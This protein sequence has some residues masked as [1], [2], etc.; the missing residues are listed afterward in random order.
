M[1]RSEIISKRGIEYEPA[2]AYL[3]ALVSGPFVFLSGT[4]GQG[5]TEEAQG[6]SSF[7]SLGACLESQ[8]GSLRDI[9]RVTVFL[10]RLEAMGDVSRVLPRLSK[11]PAPY[12]EYIPATGFARDEM[13]VEIQGTAVVK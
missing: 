1:V 9:R 12:T 10:K 7:E 8:G 3:R 11:E 13:L 4:G 5:A 2:R 6:Q